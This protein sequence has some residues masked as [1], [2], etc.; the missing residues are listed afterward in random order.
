MI[1]VGVTSAFVKV[2]VPRPPVCAAPPSWPGIR[3]PS[4]DRKYLA[5]GQN[6]AFDDP[7]Q[8]M[9]PRPLRVAQIPCLSWRLD[10]AAVTAVFVTHGYVLVIS[11]PCSFLEC[12]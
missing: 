7:I 9:F 5:H 8:T 12:G 1:G 3:K 2:C 4:Q 6:D 11:V 10:A